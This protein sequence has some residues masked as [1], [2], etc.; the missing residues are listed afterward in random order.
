MTTPSPEIAEHMRYIGTTAA[1]APEVMHVAT[2]P[3]P[4]FGDNDVLIKVEFAGVNRPDVA[5]RA[6]NYAP[7]PGASPIMGLEVS[8]TIAAIGAAVTHWRVGDA[9]CA[10]TP[11]GGY[12]EYCSAPAAHCLP[13][14]RGLSMLEAAVRVWPDMLAWPETCSVR[15]VTVCRWRSTSAS[16]VRSLTPSAPWNPSRPTCETRSTSTS[17]LISS[18]PSSPTRCTR[19]RSRC[20]SVIVTMPPSLSPRRVSSDEGTLVAVAAGRDPG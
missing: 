8:G 11:G 1:G 2:G 13:A 4:T 15:P 6:G 14:P 17:W 19:H 20:G 12:A 7:P 3:L 9:V 5:Q 10:L 16:T 18:L